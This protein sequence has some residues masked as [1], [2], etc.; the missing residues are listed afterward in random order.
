M[1]RLG[2]LFGM[3]LLTGCQG[4]SSDDGEDGTGATEESGAESGDETGGTGGVM[5][6]WEPGKVFPTPAGPTARGFLDR[7][8]FIHSHSPYSHDACD[9][10]PMPD[11]KPDPNCMVNLREAICLVEADFM[12]LTDHREFFSDYDFPDV[13]LY[14]AD[15]G[16]ELIERGGGSVANRARCGPVD[17]EI[18]VMAGCE[19]ATMPVGLEGHVADTPSGRSDIY[20][21]ATPEAISA[22]KD[23]GAVVLVAHTESWEVDD[24]IDLPLDGFEMYNLHANLLGN[25]PAALSLVDK[26]KNGDPG[27][28]HPDLIVFPIFWEDPIYLSKWAEVLSSGARRVTTMGTDSHENTFQDE[29]ADGE[30]V[31][32]FR[33][34]MLWFSNHLLVEANEDGSFDDAALKAALGAGRLYGV[35]EYLGYAEGFDFHAT[36]GGDVVEMGGEALLGDGVTLEVTMPS[37]QELDPDVEAPELSIHV[38]RAEGS[39]WVEVASATEDLSFEVSEAGAYRVEVRM[40]PRHVVDHLGD[41]ADG[42]EDDRVWIYSNPIFVE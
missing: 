17:H 32:S 14:N 21:D 39:E 33:R 8:G 25:F 31:D 34:M 26:V 27:L 38:Y 24:L 30:R 40:V 6:P 15:F 9:D 2:V 4:A 11:G 29:L 1:Q 42:A 36:S 37:V 7:R 13:L 19:S 41:Y 22:Y 5:G 23:K 16:D 35:F 18:L 20:G 12:F 28:P 3:A 10:N